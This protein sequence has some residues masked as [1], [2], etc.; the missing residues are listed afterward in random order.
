MTVSTHN[1]TDEFHSCLSVSRLVRY[2]YA[3]AAFAL[4]A[5]AAAEVCIA[6]TFSLALGAGTVLLV[7]H[8]CF[9]G[10]YVLHAIGKNRFCAFPC[11]AAT[12]TALI[13]FHLPAFTQSP[14]RWHLLACCSLVGALAF[15]F[16]TYQAANA[17]HIRGLC[18]YKASVEIRGAVLCLL[19]TLLHIAWG[20]GVPYLCL[21]TLGVILWLNWEILFVR[22]IYFLSCLPLSPLSEDTSVSVVIPTLNEE[23]YLPMLLK[24]LDEQT[25]LPCEVIVVDSGSTDSTVDVV[26]A[27]SHLFPVHVVLIDKYGC[28]GLLRNVGAQRAKGDTILFLDADTVLPSGQIASVVLEMKDRSLGAMGLTLLPLSNKLI[29]HFVAAAYRLWLKAVQFHNPR[30]VGSGILVRREIAERVT[31]D[32]TIR[33]SEDFE[34]IGRVSRITRYRVSAGEPILVSWRRFAYDGRLRLTVKYMLMELHRQTL[35]EIRGPLFRYDFGCFS[36]EGGEG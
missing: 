3:G 28:V 31:F 19:G 35:G 1:R 17:D 30:G 18:T 7:A 4:L 22:R 9:G 11:L 36:D 34:Y 21:I 15:H 5:T 10:A 23:N 14:A 25:H 12:A 13:L 20:N 2:V 32:E 26:M 27:S 29:D 24:S 33:L 16:A 8:M 6:G